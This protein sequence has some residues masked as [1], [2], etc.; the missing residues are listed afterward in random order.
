MSAAVQRASSSALTHGGPSRASR[1]LHAR[2]S[3]PRDRLRVRCWGPARPDRDER[4]VDVG[5][6]RRRQLDLGLLGGLLQAL[7]RDRVVAQL[8][9]VLDPELLGQELDDDPIEVVAAEHRVTRGRQDLED[10]VL[11]RQDRDVEGAAAEV[12]DRDALG[13]LARSRSRRPGRPRSAR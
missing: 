6:H 3:S 10:A 9:P 5:G 8:D 1:S 11:D 4:Q 2:S 12:V 7:Q 13:V